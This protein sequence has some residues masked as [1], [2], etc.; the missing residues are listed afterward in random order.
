MT[1][2]YDQELA[3]YRRALFGGS[4]GTPGNYEDLYRCPV[5]DP[6]DPFQEGICDLMSSLYGMDEVDFASRPW[7]EN[8]PT[9]E[10]YEEEQLAYNG[11]WN[12][13]SR[14]SNCLGENFFSLEDDTQ[15]IGCGSS[16]GKTEDFSHGEEQHHT[17]FSYHEDGENRSVCDYCPWDAYGG[18][19]EFHDFCRQEPRIQY[20][21]NLD[22]MRLFESIF[23]Y[24]PCLFREN[25]KNT[26]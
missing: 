8:E 17:Y 19:E 12:W 26:W 24:W 16:L 23:G 20:G 21:Y 6:N 22:E 7:E 13:P 11:N 10:V 1:N 14:F 5:F 25:Q 18:E 4:P 9:E 15:D 2:T 3:E